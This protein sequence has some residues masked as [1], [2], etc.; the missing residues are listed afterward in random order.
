MHPQIFYLLLATA[1]FIVTTIP[2][3]LSKVPRSMYVLTLRDLTYRV[4][5]LDAT[6]SE[7]VFLCC[8]W[9]YPAVAD[10]L[11]LCGRNCFPIDS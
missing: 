8:D 4:I 10:F 7:A 5:V 3:L 1:W 9:A 11:N 2:A 6:N